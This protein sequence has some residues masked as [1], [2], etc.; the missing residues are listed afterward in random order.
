[1]WLLLRRDR[2]WWIFLA[3][4]GAL[5]ALFLVPA[6]QGSAMAR[7]APLLDPLVITAVVLALLAGLREVRSAE[8]RGFWA[9]T[10]AGYGCWWLSTVLMWVFAHAQGRLGLHLLVD[11]LYLLLFIFSL[12]AAELRPD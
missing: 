12:A 4:L 5:N 7:V 3:C 11:T 10:A 2:G 6:P 9:L 1:M 8:E